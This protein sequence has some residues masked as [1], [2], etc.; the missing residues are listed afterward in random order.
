ML[1]IEADVSWTCNDKTTLATLDSCID[2]IC[3]PMN[4]RVCHI[5]AL[6]A[7]MRTRVVVPHAN[8]SRSIVV[9]VAHTGHVCVM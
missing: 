8:V 9:T 6:R 3:R 7:H 5:P 1:G 2:I 4:D